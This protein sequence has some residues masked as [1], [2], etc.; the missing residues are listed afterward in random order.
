MT[1]DFVSRF[2]STY[3]AFPSGID[4]DMLIICQGGPLPTDLAVMFSG[5]NAKQWPHPNEPGWDI[6]AYQ[7]AAWGPCADYDM[8]LCL[9]ESNYFHR[10]GWLKRFVDVWE[11]VG[12]GMYG[13]YGSN[14]VRTHL[15]TTAFA[16]SPDML[17]Q[18][19]KKVSSKQDRYQFEHGERAF[20]RLLVKKGIPVRMVTWDGDWNPRNF[21]TPRNIMWRGDQSN[22]LMWCNHSDHYHDAT[23]ERKQNWSRSIDRPYK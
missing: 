13:P 16:C 8:M 3:Q 1:G 18:Y 4:H 12:S 5:M 19:P 10:E 11:R 14:V 6:A 22:L 2:V 9:G 21:R 20:W 23:P 17:R 7:D 15:Q